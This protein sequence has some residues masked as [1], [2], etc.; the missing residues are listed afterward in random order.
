M[1]IIG[2]KMKIQTLTLSVVM[3]VLAVLT[4][5]LGS[6][7]Y[8]YYEDTAITSFALGTLNRYYT[9]EAS[10]GSDSI[11]KRTLDCSGYVFDIDQYGGLIWNRDSLPIEIDASKVICTV[12]AKNSGSV[13]IKSMT[14]DSLAYYSATDSIDFT[15][16]RE[17]LAY[18]S[19]GMNYRSYTVS[20]N[21]HAEVGDT[22]IWT[23]MADA[24]SAM[25]DLED[26]HGV[27]DGTTLYLFGS[28][29]TNTRLFITTVTGSEAW[30]ER[31]IA[32]AL[33]P[34]AAKS[35]VLFGGT[36]YTLSEGQLLR[37]YD[38]QYWDVVAEADCRQLLGASSAHLYALSADGTS[39][40]C[41][42]DEGQSWTEEAL[43]DDGTLL[44]TEDIS[45]ACRPLT[46]NAYTDKIV[47]IGNRSSDDYPS[48]TT[49]VVW[50]KVDEYGTGARSNAWLYAGFGEDNLLNRAPRAN[51]W[52]AINYDDNNIKAV[53]GK[54]KGQ[55]TAVALDRV[56][57]SGDDGITWLNDSIMS[58]PADLD[59]STTVFAFVADKVDSVWLICGDTGQVWKGRINRVAWKKDQ[60]YF[61]E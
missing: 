42:G 3:A 9:I 25:A 18:S 60:D 61:F 10:D 57:H 23:R 2:K 47:L 28:D 35:M 16:P 27:S 21:V 44:P 45:F 29:G 33:S 30:T 19:S 49:A 46:T 12:T 51:N 38:A 55:S 39:I 50:T 13:L 36:F 37:S 17:F 15:E 11:I 7:E 5:C 43:D 52:Q 48:D 14:S 34:A 4:S 26:M 20:V 32:P 31:A 22:C 8:T 1:H 59:R 24:D 6:T 53:C 54:G 40:L 41:S 56:Y 58:L